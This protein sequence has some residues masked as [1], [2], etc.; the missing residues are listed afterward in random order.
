MA[1][2]LNLS[3]VKTIEILSS[4]YLDYFKY[5]PEKRYLFGLIIIEEGFYY[6]PFLFNEYIYYS[7]EDLLNKNEY[8]ID[9]DN[10]VYLKPRILFKFENYNYIQKY[11][12]NMKDVLK[13][14]EENKLNEY[15]YVSI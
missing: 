4:E 10:K 2:I 14:V 7:K 13:F 3:Q 12:D 1:E 15:P 8:I 6:K 9:E 5:K 11:F